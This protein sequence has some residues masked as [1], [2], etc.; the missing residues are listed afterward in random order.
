M[1]TLF[2]ATSLAFAGFLAYGLG[3]HDSINQSGS[4]QIYSSVLQD[5]VPKSKDSLRKKRSGTGSDSLN[6]RDT[7]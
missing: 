5:T 1:K 7:S 3:N 2:L 4:K 6:R